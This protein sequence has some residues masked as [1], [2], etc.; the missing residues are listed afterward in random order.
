MK[1]DLKKALVIF[2]KEPK[3]GR[4][5]TRLARDLPVS[6]VTKLYKAFL[7]DIFNLARNVKCQERFLFYAGSSAHIPF[8][9]R[10][11]RGFQLKRQVGPNLGKRMYQ[12]FVHCDKKKYDQTII[13]GSDC[14]DIAPKD[15]EKAFKQLLKHDCVIGPS[16][17]GGYYLIGLKRP[18]KKI[19][20]GIPWSTENVLASTLRKAH[21]NRL[22]VY[23]LPPKED[24][25]TM[26]SLKKFAKKID[27]VRIAA[28]TKK[29]LECVSLS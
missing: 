8:L 12:A 27:R 24:I 28:Y 1:S 25:D 17:D 23:L 2:G 20:E 13:I 14:L 16:K 3:D 15:I 7:K 21:Q 22:S 11:S 4:V 9:K 10:Y 29:Q 5:K 19:F 26:K 18:T 6:F